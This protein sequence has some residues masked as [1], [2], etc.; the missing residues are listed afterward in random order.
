MKLSLPA[1]VFA[2]AVA[3]TARTLPQR[4]AVPILA[5]LL[6]E[7]TGDDTLIV[8]AFDYDISAKCTVQADVAEPG[9]VV[10]SGRLLAEVAKSL[11]HKAVELALAGGEVELRCGTAEFGLATMPVEDFPALPEPPATLGQV[12]AP[13][14]RSALAQVVPAASPDETLIM[15]TGVRVDIDADGLELAATDRYR[16]AARKIP[17]QPTVDGASA[18]VL[19][20]SKTLKDAGKG[21]ADGPVDIGAD[22]SQFALTSG[23]RQLVTRLLDSEF[24]NYRAAFGGVDA[25]NIARVDKAPLIE[26]IKRVTLVAERMTAV[27]LAFTGE[28]VEVSAGGGDLGRGSE[29][30]PCTLDGAAEVQVSFL[31]QFIVDGLHG[32]QGDVATISMLEAHKPV[33][34]TGDDPSYRYLA[35]SLRQA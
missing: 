28:Q 19:V 17:F 12:D 24:I 20:P 18:G 4:P 22:D 26:A 1:D 21:F 29:A 6:L 8:S 13:L 3:W 30:L 31:P 33:L 23:G 35:M 11:P 5:G 15:L 10:V 25:P 9:R 7:A 34:V 16:I 32:V 2:D 27:R 14:L